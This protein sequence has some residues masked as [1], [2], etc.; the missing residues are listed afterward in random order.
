MAKKEPL[1][2]YEITLDEFRFP[3]RLPGRK[4]NFRLIVE[5]RYQNKRGDFDTETA[6]LPGLDTFW[7][8]QPGAHAKE[9]FVRKEQ[10]PAARRGKRR[11]STAYY[12]PEVEV[13]R[14]DAWDRLVLRLRALQLHRLKVT[15][16]DVNRRNWWDA[17]VD[18]ASEFAGGVIDRAARRAK[19]ETRDV[20]IAGGA[21]G[22]AFGS[23]AEHVQAAVTRRLAGGTETN[24]LYA[25]SAAARDYGRVIVGT[26]GD[27]YR[28]AFRIS[29]PG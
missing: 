26:E 22:D 24:V 19:A 20:P 3:A 13:E 17:L 1:Y 5:L 16:L 9:N 6:V 18:A 11:G 8:C 12:L 4:A 10:P 7:E 23:L 15:V 27:G 28:L 21:A 25:A 29:D 14:I 2:D